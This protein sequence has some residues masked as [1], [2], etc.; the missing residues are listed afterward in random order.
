MSSIIQ[1][2]ILQFSLIYL[3]L[4]VVLALMK[5]SKIDQTKLLLVGTMRM[6]VRLV[7]A[8]FIL[9]YIFATPS[10]HSGLYCGYGGFF[11]YSNFK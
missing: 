10:F 3:L 4:I 5:K 2:N 7:L 6:T 1:L 9:T 11:H 8:G